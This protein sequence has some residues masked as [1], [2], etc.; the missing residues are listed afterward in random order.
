MHRRAGNGCAGRAGATE[1]AGAAAGGI[2]V[3]MIMIAIAVVNALSGRLVVMIGYRP[4]AR[5]ADNM[6]WQD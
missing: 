2:V 5:A 6:K 3:H 1:A 4:L